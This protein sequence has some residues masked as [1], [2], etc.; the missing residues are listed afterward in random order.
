MWR[1]ST[2]TISGW[3]PLLHEFRAHAEDIL[4]LRDV[5]AGKWSASCWIDSTS[6]AQRFDAIFHSKLIA[7]GKGSI[8]KT[9]TRSTGS[10]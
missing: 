2:V 3:Q 10:T 7:T 9:L 8:F 5:V 4:P 1:A 6:I